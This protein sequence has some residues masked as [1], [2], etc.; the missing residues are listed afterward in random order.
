[1]ISY[2]H[3]TSNRSF[4]IRLKIEANGEVVVTSPPMVPTMVIEAFI[5]DNQAWIERNL[6]KVTQQRLLPVTES[7]VMIFGKTYHLELNNAL[8]HQTGVVINGDTVSIIPVAQAAGTLEGSTRDHRNQLDR[9]L[10]ATA[11][12]YIAPRTYALAEKMGV[13]FTT[14]SFRQQKT[15]WGS[16]SSRGN[17]QFNWRLVHYPPAIIDYVIIHELAHRTHMNHSRAF[18][19]RVAQFDSDYKTHERWLKDH[20]MSV[21]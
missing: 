14:L 5:R 4:S 18:W 21:G 12:K 6:A 9:F 19:Q 2:R 3:V 13:S 20:G 1:M 8:S 16:C 17:L 15:R 11:E 7:T 10:K